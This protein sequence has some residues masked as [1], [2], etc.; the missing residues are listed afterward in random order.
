M[1]PGIPH[2]QTLLA[3][4]GLSRQLYPMRSVAADDSQ[5]LT[6]FTPGQVKSSNSSLIFTP[7]VSTGPTFTKKVST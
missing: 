2:F 6:R 5:S 7:G 3:S 4:F 1:N